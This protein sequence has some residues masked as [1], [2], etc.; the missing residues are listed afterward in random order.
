MEF[1]R[2][3]DPYILQWCVDAFNRLFSLHV[4]NDF[5]LV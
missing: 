4:N 3:K 1:S 5:V 2:T